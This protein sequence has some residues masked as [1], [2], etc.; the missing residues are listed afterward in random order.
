MNCSYLFLVL[1]L[2][3]T[4][5]AL[6]TPPGW[7]SPAPPRACAAA[8]GALV[9]LTRE[10][11]KNAKLGSLLAARG[12]ATR[13][14]PCIA[15]ERLPG[16]DDLRAALGAADELGWVA[17]TSP[18]AA[19][20]FLE[21]WRASAQP[22]VRVAS[23]GAGTAKLLSAGGVEPA[24]VPS[25]ATAKTLAAEL[26]LEAGVPPSVLYPASALAARTLEDGLRARGFETRR[27]DTYTTVG[28]TWDGA[29]E[30]AA[31]EAAVVTFAS[32]SA[33]R[34]WAERAGT[35]AAAICIG[36]TSAVEARG[37]GFERVIF[38][39]KPGVESWA[40]CVVKEVGAE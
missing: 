13:E 23:V 6:L 7:R 25:K 29:A 4:D 16:F 39:E 9:F 19:G 15:F 24:F 1:A 32:P 36:E 14:L 17:I 20:T 31:A 5:A 30:R 34:I 11:G 28:A 27:I 21:A 35:A 22:A 10:D 18:E 3:L 2:P 33:V 37:V 40:E 12:V 26:P 38:P 8:S